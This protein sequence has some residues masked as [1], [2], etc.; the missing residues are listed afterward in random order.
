M[1]YNSHLGNF[2]QLPP[3]IREQIWLELAPVGQDTKLERVQKADLSILRTSKY[4]HNEISSVLFWHSALELEL[5]S[6][7]FSATGWVVAHFEHGRSQRKANHSPDDTRATWIFKSPADAK[8]RG[9]Y[10][11]PFDK[12]DEVI[13]NLFAPDP[14]DGAKLFLLYK[15]VIELVDILKSTGT[16]QKLTLRLRKN[17]GQDWRDNRRRV[18]KSMAY[19]HEADSRYDYDV[20]VVPFCTLWNIKAVSVEAHSKELESA[21][22]WTIINW[23]V[24]TVLARAKKRFNL[25]DFQ[26]DVL[27]WQAVDC[28]AQCDFIWIHHLLWELP[29]TATANEQRLEFFSHW[30]EEGYSGCSDFEQRIFRIITLYPEI[31]ELYDPDLQILEELHSTMVCLHHYIRIYS[32]KRKLPEAKDFWDPEAW[33]KAFPSGISAAKLTIVRSLL[34]LG[35]YTDYVRRVKCFSTTAGVIQEWRSSGLCQTDISASSSTSWEK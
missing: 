23:V 7:Y 10:D 8:A 21:M 20:V 34:N 24:G 19:R 28:R 11:F 16:I 31:I 1:V 35:V 33:T 29:P 9:F 15:K 4:L 6:T 32:S 14:R 2:S 12:V 5:S 22:N 26:A 13:V 18:N 30:F 3:E 27:A 25:A 17:W